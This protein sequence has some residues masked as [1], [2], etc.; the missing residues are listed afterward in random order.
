[1]TASDP[2]VTLD[3]GAG[4]STITLLDGDAAAV[5]IVAT[6][7][8]DETGPVDGVFTLTQST[9]AVSDTVISYTVGGTATSGSDFTALAGTVDIPDSA[10][11]ATFTLSPLDDAEV[12]ERHSS[13]TVKVE[14]RVFAMPR[15]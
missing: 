13:I 2:G 7:D 12:A 1:M 10:T 9:I 5:S 14:D 4:A 6:T 3:A 8:G 15:S 11:S